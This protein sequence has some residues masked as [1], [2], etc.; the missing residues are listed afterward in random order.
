MCKFDELF[1]VSE[2][3]TFEGDKDNPIVSPGKGIAITKKKVYLP[4]GPGNQ[5]IVYDREIDSISSFIFF[6]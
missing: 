2:K 3:F 6:L 5:I 1:I 4:D